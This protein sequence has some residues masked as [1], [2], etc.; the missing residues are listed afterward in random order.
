MFFSPTDPRSE[1]EI[2]NELSSLIAP[3]VHSFICPECHAAPTAKCL[4]RKKDGW[5]ESKAPHMARINLAT[6]MYLKINAKKE[7]KR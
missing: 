1:D 4:D 7:Q 2:I 5:S 6:R 3:T